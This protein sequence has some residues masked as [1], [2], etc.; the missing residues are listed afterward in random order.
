MQLLICKW[1][2][3][4][5]DRQQLAP[6]SETRS[7]IH[8]IQRST[9]HARDSHPRI[10]YSLAYSNCHRVRHKT[11]FEHIQRNESCRKTR[12]VSL[13]KSNNLSL[14][15]PRKQKD[16]RQSNPLSLTRN[17]LITEGLAARITSVNPCAVTASCF[18][19]VRANERS[20]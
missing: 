10:H 9:L 6:L 4:C 12:K 5:L 3:I 11:C 2:S 1:C 8:H 18:L 14:Q 19:I 17:T 16:I 15:H 7:M 13:N 20:S